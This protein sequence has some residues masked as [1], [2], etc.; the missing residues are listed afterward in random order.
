MNLIKKILM[1]IV[2]GVW[3][4]V[5]LFATICLLSY[6]EFATTVLG[7][8]TL[9]IIDS[10]E[11]EPKFVEGDLLVIK[12]ESDSKINVGDKVFY[13]NSAMNTTILVYMGEVEE[14]TPVTKTETTYTIEGERV[15]GEYLIGRADNAKVYHKAGT[16][17][18]I[19]TS[20]WGFLF[21]ILSPM[22]FAIIY[23]VM[24]IIEAGKKGNKEEI[25][26]E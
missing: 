3:F 12:R 20:Q 22:L 6:N 19:L 26:Q 16:I 25:E 15:S 14:K 5:A 24:M 11:L 21:F 10:D 23:E 13:Y 17:L 2:F 9:L 4:V 1:Y 7:K 8:N 18:S